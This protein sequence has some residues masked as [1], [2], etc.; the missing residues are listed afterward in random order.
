VISK[1]QLNFIDAYIAA[2]KRGTASVLPDYP[3][4]IV[5]GYEVLL[6]ELREVDPSWLNKKDN[7][8]LNVFARLKD[9]GLLTEYKTD[10]DVPHPTIALLPEQFNLIELNKIRPSHFSMLVDKFG[11]KT[12]KVNKRTTDDALSSEK[13]ALIIDADVTDV[14]TAMSTAKLVERLLPVLKCE[15]TFSS[16][17]IFSVAT[18]GTGELVDVEIEA[19]G[20]GDKIP[21]ACVEDL[22]Y[23]EYYYKQINI[24]LEE[25]F[26][27]GRVLNEVFHNEFLFFYRDTEKKLFK[28]RGSHNRLV[29]NEVNA[30]LHNTNFKA[31]L[32]NE[33]A[34]NTLFQKLNL[35]QE[36][37][38][39]NQ[40][41]FDLIKLKGAYRR[42]D[43]ESLLPQDHDTSHIDNPLQNT[44]DFAPPTIRSRSD[45][46]LNVA[47]ITDN[48]RTYYVLM[49]P[50]HLAQ[51]IL[52]MQKKAQQTH[53]ISTRNL[54]A[55]FKRET[56]MLS[57]KAN[58]LL[59]LMR[60]RFYSFF[61]NGRKHYKERCL[62]SFL[63]SL[64][65]T[66]NTDNVESHIQDLFK[67]VLNNHL[68]VCAEELHSTVRQTKMQSVTFALENAKFIITIKNLNPH[69]S[70]YSKASASRYVIFAHE[71]TDVER[72]RVQELLSERKLILPAG[73]DIAVELINSV[74]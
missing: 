58:G 19:L 57:L 73:S 56:S 28:S 31:S 17:S 42:T 49:L 34:D 68:V 26:S 64:N 20:G 11:K 25:W 45:A 12:V 74:D 36:G 16:Q 44:L 39:E 7:A 38:Q 71:A 29:I 51:K 18:P 33:M 24:A 41:Y 13:K 66:I 70:K 4:L 48:Q 46:K 2:A 72:Q 8:V 50:P 69:F 53:N 62:K 10:D 54:L 67:L 21:L 60:D 3:G 32:V 55:L 35:I 14:G 27:S 6:K 22:K 30:R 1:Q 63:M 52:D 43:D 37:D 23:L 61:T 9:K 47:N 40:V 5:F 65:A 59:I 15:K